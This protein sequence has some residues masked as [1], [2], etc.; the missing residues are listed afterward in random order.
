[1]AIDYAAAQKRFVR[2]KSQLTRAQNTKDH[3]KVLDACR[4]FFDYYNQAEAEPMPDAWHRWQRA[5]DD[6]LFAQQRAQ[7]W[8]WR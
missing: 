8:N 6:A 3:R 7:P 2:F 4:Q 5:Q 1:M